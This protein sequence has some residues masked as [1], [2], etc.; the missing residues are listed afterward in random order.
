MLQLV[1]APLSS[2]VTHAFGT[3]IGNV[4]TITQDTRPDRTTAF[5]DLAEP[6]IDSNCLAYSGH[7]TLPGLNDTEPGHWSSTAIVDGVGGVDATTTV[8]SANYTMGF[9]E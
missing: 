4:L 5:I 3:L 1:V 8:W 7:T 9:V 6:V 2:A